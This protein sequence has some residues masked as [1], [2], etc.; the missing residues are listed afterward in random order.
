MLYYDKIDVSEGIDVNKT[1]H[2]PICI[3]WDYCY[4]LQVNFKCKSKL[5]NGCHDSMQ[6]AMSPNAAIVSV[7]GNDYRTHFCMRVRMKPQIE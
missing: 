6:K 1:N 4:T 7:K 3:I 5:C 2:S